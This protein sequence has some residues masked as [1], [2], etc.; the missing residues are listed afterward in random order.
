VADQPNIV[1]LLSDQH[2]AD[3]LGAN[4]HPVVQTPKMDAGGRGRS[5]RGCLF[6]CACICRS[7]DCPRMEGEQCDSVVASPRR[8]GASPTK[9]GGEIGGAKSGPSV[10]DPET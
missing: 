7:P 10:L 4:G 6:T 5:L 8:H 2:R 1:W 9:Q 3:A